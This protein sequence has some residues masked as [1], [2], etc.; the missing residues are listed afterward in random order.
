MRGKWLEF[1]EQTFNSELD[2]AK[3][4]MEDFIGR[5]FL[6]DCQEM[7]YTLRNREDESSWKLKEDPNLTMKNYSSLTQQKFD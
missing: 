7:Y 3:G 1:Q 4:P 6:E 5:L 2:N